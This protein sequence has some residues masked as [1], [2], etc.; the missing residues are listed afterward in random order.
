MDFYRRIVAE[1]KAFLKTGGRLLLE[2]GYRQADDVK[3]LL[4]ENNW[5][6]VRFH[7]DFQGINRVVEASL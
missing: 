2:V 7:Q 3:L 5:R 6:E 1:A 4:E